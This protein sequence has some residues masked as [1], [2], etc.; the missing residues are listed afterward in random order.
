MPITTCKECQ[1]KV[2]L[3]AHVCPHCGCSNP[4][5]SWKGLVAGIIVLIVILALVVAIFAGHKRGD[6]RAVSGTQPAAALKSVVP[7]TPRKTFSMTP[8]ALQQALQRD[9]N[10]AF[11]QLATDRGGNDNDN[12]TFHLS[13]GDGITMAGTVGKKDGLIKDLTLT[14]P[15]ENDGITPLMVLLSAAHAMTP[16]VPKEEINLA[17]TEM[18][19]EATEGMEEGISI[20]KTVG[21]Q[22]YAVTADSAT[23]LKFSFSPN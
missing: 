18:I 7:P 14:L 13:L 20:E 21:S 6:K 4:A 9:Q 3:S 11:T 19:K 15:R 8:E 12:D 2:S 16:D 1:R 23:E 5:G 17:V 22:Q 10:L